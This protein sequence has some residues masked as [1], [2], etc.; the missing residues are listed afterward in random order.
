VELHHRL[1]TH[2]LFPELRRIEPALDAVVRRLDADHEVVARHLEEIT[3]AADAVGELDT[4]DRRARLIAGIGALAADLLTHL[5][6]E[7]EQLS[8]VLRTLT[9]WPGLA[10]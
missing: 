10:G 9:Q 6:F 8:P 4:A 5:D 7:E 2:Y 1:E 3:V